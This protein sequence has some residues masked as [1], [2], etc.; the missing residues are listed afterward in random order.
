MSQS[1]AKAALMYIVKR[2]TQLSSVFR[3]VIK[4]V[5]RIPSLNPEAVTSVQCESFFSVHLIHV[6]FVHVHSFLL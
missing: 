1:A 3:T 2:K 6:N 4:I 5:N